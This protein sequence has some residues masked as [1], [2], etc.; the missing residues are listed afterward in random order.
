MS[1]LLFDAEIHELKLDE[2]WVLGVL[3]AGEREE[4]EEDEPL[5]P[6]ESPSYEVDWREQPGEPWSEERLV[7]ASWAG[8]TFALSSLAEILG[9]ARDCYTVNEYSEDGSQ[10]RGSRRIFKFKPGADGFQGGRL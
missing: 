4:I 6:F 10:I 3:G 5:S 2:D 8:V 9:G 1:Q 7:V